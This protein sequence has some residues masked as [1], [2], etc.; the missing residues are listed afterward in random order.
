ME[1]AAQYQKKSRFRWKTEGYLSELAR[2]SCEEFKSELGYRTVQNKKSYTIIQY[3]FDMKLSIRN[4]KKI[5]KECYLFHDMNKSKRI[6][7]YLS[8]NRLGN[9]T[10]AT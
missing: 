1:F 6:R 5:L 3:F 4:F 8:L 7:K 9:S 2:D 10:R